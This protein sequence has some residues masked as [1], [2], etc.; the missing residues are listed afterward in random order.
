MTLRLAHWSRK[1]RAG[2]DWFAVVSYVAVAIAAS[3]LAWAGMW[4]LR[5][6]LAIANPLAM[7]GPAVSVLVVAGRSG[8]RGYIDE[9]VDS[10]SLSRVLEMLGAG[11]ILVP[12]LL[13]AGA[14]VAV[15]TLHQS[16]TAGAS[17]PTVV[18]AL[19]VGMLLALV[20]ASAEEIGWRGHL[21][22]AL[23][24][25]GA[26]KAAVLVGLVWG[27]WHIPA[28]VLYGYN[29]HYQPIWGVVTMTAFTVPFSVIL[30][31]ARM[32]GGSILPA[33]PFGPCRTGRR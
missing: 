5:I 20:G 29:F 24:S 22:G 11:Y 9:V 8:I 32:H 13:G 26:G 17:V 6:P 1:P 21:F 19:T 16:W 7:M 18:E 31:W 3:W 33:V 30:C 14:V 15:S 2:V 25:I 12:A 23:K 27:V 28:I 4:V 10:L